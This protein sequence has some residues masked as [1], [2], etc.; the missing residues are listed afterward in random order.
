MLREQALERAGR[1]VGGTAQASAPMV[2][3]RRGEGGWVRSLVS[4]AS[5]PQ[6]TCRHADAARCTSNG[7]AIQ[8][9]RTPQHATPSWRG[10]GGMVA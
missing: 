7:E 10:A 2:D 8:R 6:L 5:S 3:V 1:G 9:E 4:D